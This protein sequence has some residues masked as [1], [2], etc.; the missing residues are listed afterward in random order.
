M[1]G[2]L[3]DVTVAAVVLTY[4]ESIN[5][6]RCL[7]SVRWCDECLVVDSGS[8]DGTL[9]AARG[10]GARVCLHRADGIFNIANQRNWTLEHAGLT[11]RWILFLDADEEVT[12]EL[13][14]AIRRAINEDIQHYDGYEL[15]PRYMFWGRWLKRTQG[16]PNWHCRLLRNGATRFMGGVWE[17]FAVGVA[18]AA[19][20]LEDTQ[21]RRANADQ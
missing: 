20:G 18:A 2:L 8:T 10:A 1:D 19:A 4:N 15:T 6:A 11:S 5:I 21:R 13:Q 9:E 16:F 12:P 7:R 3:E 14:S 17:H